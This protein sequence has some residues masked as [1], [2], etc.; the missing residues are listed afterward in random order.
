MITTGS[1]RAMENKPP[2]SSCS[3]K[4]WLASV[5]M[6]SKQQR[7]I[8]IG[9]GIAGAA[10]AQALAKKGWQVTVVDRHAQPATEA[11]GNPQGML[12]IRLSAN[13][14]PLTQLLA[15]GYRH[16]L[17][18]L[19]H[20]PRDCYDLCGLIQLPDSDKERLRQNKLIAGQH[21]PEFFQ[22][23]SAAQLSALAGF[24]LSQDGLYFPEGG[25]LQPPRMVGWL[26]DH[27]SITF[28]GQA[29]VVSLE[30]HDGLWQVNLAEGDTLC[31][32]VVVIACGHHSRRLQQTAHL[33]LKGIRGQTTSIPATRESLKLRTVVCEDGYL[34]PAHNGRHTLGA[35]FQFDDPDGS[36]RVSDHLQNLDK[37]A[38][39]AS[40]VAEALAFDAVNI[41]QLTG[42]AAYRC[43]TPDYLPVV[44]PVLDETEFMARFAALGKNAKAKIE[45]SVPWHDGLYI[46]TGH[47]SRGLITAPLA[48]EQLAR[49]I[50]GEQ[51]CLA[52]TLRTELHP[53]RFPARAL[54][55]TGNKPR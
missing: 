48:G 14:T 55:R 35:T 54:I 29:T 52:E 2:A 37:I 27:S 36:V 7:A 50:C 53:A 43:T 32:E 9:A 23:M 21:Y 20:A 46:N 38:N 26:L 44:G 24:P 13:P 25:W 10:T 15:Q 42:K 45:A 28:Q 3:H 16:T 17:D 12:Y 19:Q 22:P 31:A 47:G 49:E 6:T 40:S 34:A 41:E 33:L 11:S 30:K 18:L 5:S 8:V 39:F 51:A 4:P 1:T